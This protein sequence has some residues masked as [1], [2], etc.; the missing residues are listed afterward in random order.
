MVGIIITCGTRDMYIMGN[1]VQLHSELHEQESEQLWPIEHSSISRK[2]IVPCHVFLVYRQSSTPTI[3]CNDIHLE[4]VTRD[5]LRVPDI[6]PYPGKSNSA[7]S[8]E[9][10]AQSTPSKY[11]ALRHLRTCSWQAR[12]LHRLREKEALTENCYRFRLSRSLELRPTFIARQS[13][14]GTDTGRKQAPKSNQELKF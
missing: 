5:Q 12:G 8:I 10:S 1:G 9:F 4:F 6:E 13:I 2:E 3:Y 11:H 7:Y 14:K